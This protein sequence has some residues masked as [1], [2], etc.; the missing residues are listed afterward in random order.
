ML[1]KED[2]RAGFE[3]NADMLSIT[4]LT[5][6]Q[7]ADLMTGLGYRAERGERVKVKAVI[8][9]ELS[10]ITPE[11]TAEVPQAADAAAPD[12]PEMEVFY[13]FKWAPLRRDRKPNPRR[14]GAGETDGSG[15]PPRKGGKS[16]RGPKG[17]GQGGKPEAARSFSAKPEKKDRIDPDNPFAQALMGLK[18][19]G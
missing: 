13:N 8:D 2:S 19:K 10:E 17:K 15:R 9:A 6:E 11:P 4:G 18:E 16:Q 7:F 3:G 1:R 14:E 12:A 5:L